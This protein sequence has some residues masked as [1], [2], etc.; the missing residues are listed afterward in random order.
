MVENFAGL[1]PRRAVAV[2]VA[3][4][5]RHFGDCAK[6]CKVACVVMAV[7]YPAVAA[8]FCVA[9]SSGSTRVALA[10]AREFAHCYALGAVA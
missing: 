9:R 6:R 8:E 3:A 1:E 10:Q 2:L 7:L 5:C 4:A